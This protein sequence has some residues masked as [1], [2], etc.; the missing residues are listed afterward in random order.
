MN[1]FSRSTD[2]DATTPPNQATEAL[3][4][5]RALD[6][7][8]Q[9]PATELTPVVTWAPL[10]AGQ[11]VHVD[12]VD[13]VDGVLHVTIDREQLLTAAAEVTGA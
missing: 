11:L 4:R 5:A 6:T 8:A 1:S 2:T 10:P 9:Q 13:R 12:H 3:R 7:V